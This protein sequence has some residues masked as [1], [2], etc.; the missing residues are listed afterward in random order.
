M[1]MIRLLLNGLVV[2]LPWFFRRKV[3]E[4]CYGYR[5]GEKAR[6][7]FSWIFPRNLVMGDNACI[8]HL[9]VVVHLDRV[10]MR[11]H[12]TVGRGN[13]IT[14]HE[15]GSGRFAH[16]EGRD[17][18]LVIGRHSAITKSHIIDC[19]DSVTIGDFT[20]IAG[21][22]SQ[23]ITHGIDVNGCRQD[24]KPIEIG[25]HCLVG[26]RVICLG[27]SR[28]PDRSVLA[29]GSVL[30]KE[31]CEVETLYAG[32]PARSVKNVSPNAGYFKRDTGYIW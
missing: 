1:S 12:S 22:H 23:I 31:F 6:I 9:N 2:L 11:D 29:A 7:G 14:G 15:H 16:R 5:F 27:G 3:L 21:Y 24:C 20:T 19:T 8:D 17:S 25:N 32:V 13:W 28:L 4:R 30:T 26:T 10:E 18:A